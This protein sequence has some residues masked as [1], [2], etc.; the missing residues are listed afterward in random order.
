MRV[1]CDSLLSEVHWYR[2][3]ILPVMLID[4]V[5]F[6]PGEDLNFGSDGMP[7]G[8]EPALDLVR[9]ERRHVRIRQSPES[10]SGG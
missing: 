1:S 5:D 6:V 2:K 3:C 10:N 8:V 7:H 9:I 4:E